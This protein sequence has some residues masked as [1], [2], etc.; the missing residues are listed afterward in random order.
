MKLHDHK[1]KTFKL[2]IVNKDVKKKKPSS[3]LMH[4]C[5]FYKIVQLHKCR[6]GAKDENKNNV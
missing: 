6:D 3:P 1:P 5:R 2:S 4:M